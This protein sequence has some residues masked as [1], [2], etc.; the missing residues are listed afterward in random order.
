MHPSTQSVLDE[1][2]RQAAFL[3]VRRRAELRGEL[4]SQDLQAGFQFG[5]QR[6][7]LVNPQ[8]GIFKPQSMRFLLSIRTV[9]PRQGARVWYEDQREAHRQ[10]YDGDEVVDYAF[11]GTNSEAAENR[12]LREAMEHRVPLIYFLGTA[13]G[14][15]QPII[16]TFV[17]E[18]DASTLKAKLSFGLPGTIHADPGET[19]VE[20]RYALRE[21]KMRLHQATFR[22]AVITAYGGRCA[23]SGLPENRLL[24]A[25]HI[26][27]DSDDR[28]GQP[29]VNNG[30]PLSKLHHAA[31]DSHLIGISPDYRVT[32]SDRL[33]ELRDGPILEALK[34]LHDSV[35][36]L[37][38]RR[39]DFPDRERLA[40]RFELFKASR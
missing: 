9:V 1:Q 7:P 39:Q 19:V 3:M 16:P 31:F 30:L 5:G 40:M 8:R 15:Y 6:F 22:A 25:A 29:I 26:A 17:A 32:I 38:Q 10:V 35:I 27:A 37:P 23:L 21:V 18:W 4:T 13:P 34:G 14:Q 36:N 2:M 24:D 12:W 20:R 33:L 28:Y 11:M